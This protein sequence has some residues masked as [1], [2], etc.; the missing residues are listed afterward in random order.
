MQ[1]FLFYL[2][3]KFMKNYLDSIG[4]DVSKNTLDVVMHNSQQHRQFEN[5]LKGFRAIISWINKTKVPLNDIL[6]CFEHTGWYSLQLCWF[7]QEQGLSFHCVPPLHLKRSLG[8]RRGKS[9]KADA[10]D[11][12]RYAWVNREDIILSHAP[13]RELIDLQRMLTLRDQFVKQSTALKNQEHA[14][15]LVAKKTSS[16]QGLK[17]LTQSLRV[18][19]KLTLKLE[20]QMEILIIKTPILAS[21]YFLLRSITGIGMILALRLI[22]HTHNF[23]RFQSW[24]QFS[25]YCGLAPYPF[26]SGTSIFR[27][28][29]THPICDKHM[30][31]LLTM[32]AI[33]AIQSDPEL[34]IYY[35]KRVDE[36]KNK[37][38]AIN[39]I[40]NKI[41]ARAFAVV[42]R[43]TP[44]IIL[45]KF[46][47]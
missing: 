14:M 18:Q 39:I 25:A 11:I 17:I 2:N 44:F 1:V 6:F 40:R 10:F 21:N 3:H 34:K 43:Q 33:S 45:A 26:Q 30:K 20:K 9:D 36:G 38:S 22:V 7:L 16:D 37:M 23:S 19:Q 24:R 46:A 13:A 12:A 31:S 42:K 27:N 8:L 35:N 15:K 5:S 47:A 4:F 41:V 29:K 32:A 28:P